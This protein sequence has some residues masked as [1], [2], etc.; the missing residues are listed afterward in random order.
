MRHEQIFSK[1][2]DQIN[3]VKTSNYSNGINKNKNSLKKVD[4]DK[5]K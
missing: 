4:I 5:N 2:K 3:H 1:T